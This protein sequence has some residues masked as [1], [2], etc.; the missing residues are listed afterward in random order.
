MEKHELIKKFEDQ[1]ESDDRRMD[2]IMKWFY[3]IFVD[4]AHKDDINAALKAI[5]TSD[6]S[7]SFDYYAVAATYPSWKLEPC[8]WFYEQ[9]KELAFKK[10]PERAKVLFRGYQQQLDRIDSKQSESGKDLI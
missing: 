2:A 5:D 4:G 8:R 3:E 6:M 10:N 9:Q 1:S 7:V